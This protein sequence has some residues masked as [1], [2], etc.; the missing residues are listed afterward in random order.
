VAIDNADRSRHDEGTDH[1]DHPV[2]TSTLDPSDHS[3]DDAGHTGIET[4]DH[5]PSWNE[6]INDDHPADTSI[7]LDPAHLPI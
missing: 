4:G 7:H 1:S 6:T 2:R 3:V 5:H